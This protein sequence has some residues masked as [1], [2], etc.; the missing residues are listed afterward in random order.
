MILSAAMMF[1]WLAQRHDDP[2]ALAVSRQINA[3]VER[4]LAAGRHLPADLGGTTSTS[5]VAQ[6]VIDELG[7]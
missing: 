5:D 7:T 6:A 2:A 4:V 3:A 1:E